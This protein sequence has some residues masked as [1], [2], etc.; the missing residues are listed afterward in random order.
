MAIETNVTAEN[1][2]YRGES[3]QIR[4]HIT[5]DLAGTTPVDVSIGYTWLW[6]L[7][8]NDKSAALIAKTSGNGIAIEGTFNASK[9]LNTQRVVV[10]LEAEDTS[11]P[12]ANPPVR[13]KAA[14]YR[15]ALWRT[16]AGS[17]QVYAHGDFVLLEASPK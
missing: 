3:N 13:I 15:H 1:R 14:T 6:T 11:N 10:T 12:A 5:S 17:E 7:A 9:A 16:T 4:F 2:V 8:K